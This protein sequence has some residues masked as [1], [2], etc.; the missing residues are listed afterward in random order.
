[1]DLD[2]QEVI[3]MAK[4]IDPDRGEELANL[5]IQLLELEK[6]AMHQKRPQLV[7]K[8]IEAIDQEQGLI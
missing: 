5:F 3:E 6:Q 2:E 4:Q 7:K 8:F 1:M